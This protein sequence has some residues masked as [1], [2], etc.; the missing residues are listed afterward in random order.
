ML[1]FDLKKFRKEKKLTQKEL[2][3]R[4]GY[5]PSYITNIETG[6]EK[7]SNN[8]LDRIE[9]VFG[10]NL[11]E[12]RDYLQGNRQSN[13]INGDVSNSQVS[14]TVNEHTHDIK[15]LYKEIS[16]MKDQFADLKDRLADLEKR[17]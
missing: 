14:Q 17:K 5:V 11:D 6:R 3:E 7:P 9:E 2:A 16:K 15:E 4:L 10:I 8:L 1:I 12:Y 13:V